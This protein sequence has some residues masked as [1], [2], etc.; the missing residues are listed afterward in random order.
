MSCWRDTFLAMLI[1]EGN[2][3]L[4]KDISYYIRYLFDTSIEDI[5]PGL[6]M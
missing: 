1:L 2:A 4:Y 5:M 6:E 3:F